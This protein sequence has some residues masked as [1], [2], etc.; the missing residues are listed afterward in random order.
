[1]CRR[2]HSI[3]RTVR[4]TVAALSMAL[5]TL[6]PA[7]SSGTSGTST[8]RTINV[9]RDAPTIQA[10]VTRARPGDLVVIEPG[11]YHEKVLIET[12]RVVVRGRDRNT[13]IID[14]EYQRES[15]FTVA[16]NGVVIENLTVRR[17]N[18]NGVF[19][20]GA[21][22]PK[23][24]QWYTNAQA[25]CNVVEVGPHAAKDVAFSPPDFAFVE[26]K[27]VP[28]PSGKPSSRLQAVDPL[29]G[30]T[31]WQI[32]APTPNLGAASCMCCA[33]AR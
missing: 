23:A 25:S 7:C 10:G 6:I 27:F 19:I 20:N 16:A 24:G 12:D 29:T 28:P 22:S 31:A 5:T 11:I 4:G 1:M 18:A 3:A 8:S 21:Y 15:G 2:D 30:K 14:G 26:L 32:D 17:F 13:V 9:P 33:G